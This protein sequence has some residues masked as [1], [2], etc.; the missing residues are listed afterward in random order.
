MP[1]GMMVP[2]AF[3]WRLALSAFAAASVL[4]S[5]V[6]AVAGS[7]VPSA[8]LAILGVALATAGGIATWRAGESTRRSRARAIPGM[9]DM[10]PP[11]I[12]R[13][14]SRQSRGTRDGDDGADFDLSAIPEFRTRRD[15]ARPLSA[16]APAP[17]NDPGPVVPVLLIPV[18]DGAETAV[19]DF[20]GAVGAIA[21]AVLM[22]RG[23]RLVPVAV[24]GNWAN[25]RAVA[26]DRGGPH[27]SGPPDES[28]DAPGFPIDDA[29]DVMLAGIAGAVPIE[30]WG[31]IEDVPAGMLPLVALGD[32]GVAV[33]VATAHRQRLLAL[34]VASSRDG[35]RRYTDVELA[36]L[37]AVA[38]DRAPVLVPALL[39]G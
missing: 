5:I 33:V 4:L 20:A 11:V 1:A 8:V 24:A 18:P 19:S 30:R 2:K 15:V 23:R 25:A 10:E 36:A 26:P 6:L 32:Q 9:L 3:P 7:V 39:D 16:P 14:R 29:L 28:N 37:E 12:G 35:A 27:G 21:A 38:R 34:W 17:L 22:R 13:D 31:E